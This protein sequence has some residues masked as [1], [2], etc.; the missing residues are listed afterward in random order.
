MTSRENLR[1]QMEKLLIAESS[2]AARKLMANSAADEELKRIEQ[3]ERLLKCLPRS[4]RT[5]VYAASLVGATCLI[6]ACVLWTF[7]LP[8]SHLQFDITSESVTIKLAK[9]IGWSGDWDLGLGLLR[10]EDMSSIEIPPELTTK[11]MLSGRA[12]LEGSNG[13][14]AL[15][16][17][18]LQ[19][20]AELSVKKAELQTLTINSW[21]APF[22]G[23]LQVSGEPKIEA[24]ESPEESEKLSEARFDIPGTVTFF[25]GAAQIP[26][27]LRVT[28]RGALTLSGLAVNEI[29]FAREE[30]GT[31][32]SFRSGVVAGHLTML[33]TD[34][35]LEPGSRLRLEGVDGVISGLTVSGEGIHLVFEGK[36]HRASLGPPGFEQEL[37]PSILDYI[38]HQQR[39]GFFWA[40]ASFIWGLLWSARTLIFR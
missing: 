23:Q 37:T 34:Q 36:V 38:Y 35:K 5:A 3:V 13:G 12:W 27:V 30:T 26:A 29:S 18:D 1:G 15:R 11:N 14:F 9:Q 25:H 33:T 16:R 28:P 40:V 22:L 24:G 31:E 4:T 32:T 20:N 10:L 39:L 19:A 21:N 2:A 6:V 7:R 17:L 8:T